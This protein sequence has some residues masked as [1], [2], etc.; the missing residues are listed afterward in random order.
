MPLCRLR[1][2]NTEIVVFSHVTHGNS[3]NWIF[4]F[5]K[6]KGFL[7]F[8]AGSSDFRKHVTGVMVGR[9]IQRAKERAA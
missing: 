4:W 5:E 6:S 7:R 1:R 2:P 8:P 3:R 9:A